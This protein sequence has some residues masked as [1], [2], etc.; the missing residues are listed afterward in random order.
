MNLGDRVIV[1]RVIVKGG[2][3][4]CT[5][6]L[7]RDSSQYRRN[8]SDVAFAE[9]GANES[10]RRKFKHHTNV[11]WGEATMKVYVKAHFTQWLHTSV[12]RTMK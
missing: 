11:E 2:Y 10:F 7:R 12:R 1:D 3:Q 8:R 4:Y 5:G 6:I 9:G